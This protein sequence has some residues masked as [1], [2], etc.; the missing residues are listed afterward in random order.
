[1]PNPPVNECVALH[2]LELTPC[3]DLDVQNSSPTVP[4][5]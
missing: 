2:E 4:K 1:M 5:F 3:T